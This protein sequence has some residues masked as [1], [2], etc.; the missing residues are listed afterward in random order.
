MFNFNREKFNSA[1]KESK[2]VRNELLI[3]DVEQVKQF[4][5]KA[6]DMCLNSTAFQS[7][8]NY[9]GVDF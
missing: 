7:R 3:S 1:L 9:P 4:V 8:M 6:L 2:D 5:E